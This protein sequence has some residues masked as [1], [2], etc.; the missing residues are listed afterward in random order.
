MRSEFLFVFVFV[1]CSCLPGKSGYVTNSDIVKNME[2]D[3]ASS[4][5]FYSSY[6]IGNF[7]NGEEM[8]VRRY[9]EGH[10]FFH[11][12]FLIGALHGNEE[13]AKKSINVME[14]HIKNNPSVVPDSTSVFV[15]NPANNTNIRTILGIDPNRDFLDTKLNETRAISAFTQTLNDEW[16]HVTIISAHQYNDEAR[17]TKGIGWVLPLYK[18]LP[19]GEK[20]LD[21]KILIQRDIH[22]TNPQASQFL[23]LEFAKILN[24][25]YEPMWKGGEM[26]PGE[27]IHFISNLKKSINMIEYEIPESKK[28]LTDEIKKGLIKFIQGVLNGRNQ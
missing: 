2:T 5:V 27:Y 10:N 3:T 8:I 17:G 20:L 15:L 18:L 11:A 6:K 9:G 14:D 21:A 26:Y 24:F 23:A 13:G 25:S 28:N 22:Y 19:E 4:D 7:S 1:I 12:V 16:E